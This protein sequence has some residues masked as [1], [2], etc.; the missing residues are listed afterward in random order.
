MQPSHTAPC[1]APGCALM[2]VRAAAVPRRCV[3]SSSVPLP[4]SEHAST[5][6]L[7]S[8][9]IT[10]ASMLASFSTSVQEAPSAWQTAWVAATP[11]SSI[12]VAG[13]RATPCTCK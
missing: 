10:G 5:V 13:S 9:S 4:C 12:A 1:T 6:S 2:W 3:D 8:M 11:S 7:G